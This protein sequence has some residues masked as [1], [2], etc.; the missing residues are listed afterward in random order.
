[1]EFF[2]TRTSIDFLRLH[3]PCALASTVAIAAALV[4]IFT[5]GINLGL[6]F[7]GGTEVELQLEQGVTQETLRGALATIVHG[8]PEVV[9]VTGV[10]GRYVVRIGHDG[11]ASA[12]TGDSIVSG[13]RE[14]L[15]ARAPEQALRAEWVGPRAGAELRDDA[16][17]AAFY[18][19]ALMLVYVVFRFDFRFAPGAIVALFH[20]AMVVVG[21]YAFTRKEFTVAT[22]AAILTI[23]GYSINDTIVIYDRVRE[24]LAR[25]RGTSLPEI[26]NLSLN[27]TLSRTVITS[28]VTMLSILGFLVWG[29]PVVKDIAFALAVGFV[30]G[31][32]S[33]VFIATPFVAWMDRRMRR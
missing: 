29:P 32:Y 2:K 7:A 16:I 24:N 14:R 5:P 3:K 23:I 28:S 1:M 25:S 4:S 26:L 8:N 22:V 30:S 11:E 13:L 6:D 10:P 33:T 19:L 12:R 31:A 27:E 17:K 9:S 21:A 20:D 18:A 15:G